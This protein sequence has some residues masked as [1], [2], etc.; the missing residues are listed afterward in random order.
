[1]NNQE[2]K[3]EEK[4]KEIRECAII[5]NVP[6]L[7]PKTSEILMEK[8]RETM[9]KDILEIGTAVGY[10]G[11]MMLSQYENS[12]LITIEKNEES[13]KIAQNNF[14]EVGY[15]DRVKILLGDCIDIL[16]TI[17]KKF[18]FIFLDGPKGQYIKYLP[19]LLE[20]LNENGILFSDNVLY[21][22][23]VNGKIPVDKKKKT[24]VKNLRLFL[25]EVEK[26]KELENE[27]LDIEDGISICKKRTKIWK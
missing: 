22:G 8:I 17:N 11:I 13:S 23:M 10:S 12:N 1:M 19:Y 7:R 9:P 26:N 4:L 21:R 3:I 2:K 15:S 24:L 14:E 5:N 25:E 16:P 27:T 6:I 20:R 18:D